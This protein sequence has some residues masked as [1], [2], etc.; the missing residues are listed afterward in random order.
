MALG[1]LPSARPAWAGTGPHD[2]LARLA[3]GLALVCGAMVVASLLI[4]AIS[5]AVGV[6]TAG[7]GMLLSV[8]V[9]GVLVAFVLATV[10]MA[11]GERWQ[12]VWLPLGVFPATVLSLVL[13]VLFLWE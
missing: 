6:D 5:A 10:A 1:P 13:A 3:V 11:R 9:P 2:R 12:R 4:T 7:I 8:G